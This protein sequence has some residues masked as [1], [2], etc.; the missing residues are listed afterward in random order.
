MFPEGLP[1]TLLEPYFIRQQEGTPRDLAAPRN[2]RLNTG[3]IYPVPG[4]IRANSVS[5][6]QA[7]PHGGVPA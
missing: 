3:V 7:V 5:L 1:L 2:A 6:A 4:Q